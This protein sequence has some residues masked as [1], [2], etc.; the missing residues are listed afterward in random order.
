VAF[1]AKGLANFLP[2]KVNKE[3]GGQLLLVKGLLANCFKPLLFEAKF[4]RDEAGSTV[5]QSEDFM[6]MEELMDGF[7]DG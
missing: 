7:I 1:L 6:L 2:R 4:N 3:A 5:G